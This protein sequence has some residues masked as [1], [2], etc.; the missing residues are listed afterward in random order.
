M[1]V[2]YGDDRKCTLG[3]CFSVLVISNISM[4]NRFALT[5]HVRIS[6]CLFPS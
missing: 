3:D 1:Q 5:S 2:F 4:G 6:F